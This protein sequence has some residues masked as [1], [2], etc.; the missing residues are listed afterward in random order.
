MTSATSLS[1]PSPP[2][3]ML[4]AGNLPPHPRGSV[5]HGLLDWT[6]SPSPHSFLSQ[7]A[8]DVRGKIEFLCHQFPNGWANPA[9]FFIWLCEVVLENIHIFSLLFILTA[10]GGACLGLGCSECGTRQGRNP[11]SLPDGSVLRPVPVLAGL[12]WPVGK[13]TQSHT[14]L[15]SSRV[16]AAGHLEDHTYQDIG[17]KCAGCC[18][19]RNILTISW[20]CPPLTPISFLWKRKGHFLNDSK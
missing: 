9:L 11:G 12:G 8:K 10:A 19:R 18:S 13:A 5:W 17:L 14:H 3:F 20:P 1:L 2:P 7:C 15:S 6:P 16:S 4:A